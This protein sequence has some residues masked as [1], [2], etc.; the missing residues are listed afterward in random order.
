ML[1]ESDTMSPLLRPSRPALL[2]GFMGR[3]D[4]LLLDWDM[5]DFWDLYRPLA[6][7][8]PPVWPRLMGRALRFHDEVYMNHRSTFRSLP[9]KEQL[10]GQQ[11]LDHPSSTLPG[12]SSDDDVRGC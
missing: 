4:F 2:P 10:H 9:L 11:Q 8:D 5:Q 7:A 6:E 1:L 12:D 3:V